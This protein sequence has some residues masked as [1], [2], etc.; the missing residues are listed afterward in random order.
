MSNDFAA[1][2]ILDRGRWTWIRILFGSLFGRVGPLELCVMHKI[3]VL[4]NIVILCRVQCHYH[5][6]VSICDVHNAF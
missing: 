5:Y 3:R 1:S 2:D 4:Y 6:H